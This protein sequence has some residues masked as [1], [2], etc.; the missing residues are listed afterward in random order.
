MTDEWKEKLEPGLLGGVIH[1]LTEKSQL[2]A[3]V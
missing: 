3:S 1:M 2:W